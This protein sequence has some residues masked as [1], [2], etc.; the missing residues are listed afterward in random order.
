MW[1]WGHSLSKISS[2]GPVLYGTK[3]LLWCPDKQ[4]PI[5]HSKCRINKGLIK[6]RSILHHW[7]LRC[8]GW[9]IMAHPSYIHSFI[10]STRMLG[11]LLLDYNFIS[12]RKQWSQSYI[13]TRNRC[14]FCSIAVNQENTAG[15]L[16]QFLQC[17]EL[18]RS[19][20]V[21]NT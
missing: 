14:W 15:I 18:L 20:W 9:M 13:C 16:N 3:W 19:I 7:S 1:L 8:K 12:F 2:P 11:N 10:H 4:S 21:F 17:H 5:F 6:R